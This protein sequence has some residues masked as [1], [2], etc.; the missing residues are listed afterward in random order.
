MKQQKMSKCLVVSKSNAG[1]KKG[2]SKMKKDQSD[3]SGDREKAALEQQKHALSDKDVGHVKFPGICS[4][5][6]AGSVTEESLM[7]DGKSK[8]WERKVQ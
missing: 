4:A 6:A 7:E 2:E 5:Q 8:I 3:K 1:S